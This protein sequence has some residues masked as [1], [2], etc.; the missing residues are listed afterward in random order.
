MDT[1]LDM[2]NPDIVVFLR[3]F[4]LKQLKWVFVNK[5]ICPGS[6]VLA[7]RGDVVILGVETS[8][9]VGAFSCVSVLC[10]SEFFHIS[11][12]QEFCVVFQELNTILLSR[13][14]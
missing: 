3:N 1:H 12:I 4:Q 10:E 2:S 9:A 6:K 14:N 5:P 13:E 7:V 11:K 8:T